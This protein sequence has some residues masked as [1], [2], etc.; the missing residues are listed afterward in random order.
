MFRSTR[1]LFAQRQ[2]LIKFLG[3]RHTPKAEE[4]KSTTPLMLTQLL[5]PTSSQNL[6][7]LT[8]AERSNTAL[9]ADSNSSNHSSKTPLHLDK[10]HHPAQQRRKQRS[11]ME[12]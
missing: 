8:A 12:Q 6:S 7:P 2:P 5:P 1:A 4:Q 9:S 10:V 11:H 3:K